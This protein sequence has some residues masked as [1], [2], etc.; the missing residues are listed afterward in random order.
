MD[1]NKPAS[2]AY[3]DCLSTAQI[4][5]ACDF[6]Q[7]AQKSRSSGTFKR[8]TSERQTTFGAKT[9]NAFP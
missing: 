7:K 4:R 3:R 9:K 2:M 6:P 1:M 8:L 5:I